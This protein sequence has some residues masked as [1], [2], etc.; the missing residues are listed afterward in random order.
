MTSVMS[1]DDVYW[2]DLP[3]HEDERG[4]LTAVESVKDIPFAIKRIFYMHSIIDDRAAHAHPNTDQVIIA[5]S[6]SFKMT[7]SD[8]QNKRTYELND[9]TRAVL[10]PHMIF[11]ELTDFSAGAVCM[12]LANTHY[13]YAK[14]IRSWKEYLHQLSEEL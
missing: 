12:V 6:G 10:V 7:V 11:I 1:L 3:S 2:I 14:V 4:V 8:G 5:I 9:P 13:E